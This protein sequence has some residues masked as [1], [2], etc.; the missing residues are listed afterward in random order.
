MLVLTRRLKE[1]I[2]IGDQITV[3]VLSIKGNQV[4]LGIE[5]PAHV[6]VYRN[7]IYAKIVTE[8]HQAAATR[9][10]DIEASTTDTEDGVA[11]RARYPHESALCQSHWGGAT[12]N[13]EL[14]GSCN[15]QLQQASWH[16]AHPCG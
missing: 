11:R 6:K 8:N 1:G 14:V 9:R 12:P 10:E 4:Q 13:G 5:A 7:E 2:T 3:T 16:T 15:H